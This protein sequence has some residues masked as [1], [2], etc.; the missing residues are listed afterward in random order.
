[1]KEYYSNITRLTLIGHS[2]RVCHHHALA[3]VTTQI[4]RMFLFS[5]SFWRWA[6]RCVLHMTQSYEL[7]GTRI[8]ELSYELSGTRDAQLWKQLMRASLTGGRE[9]EESG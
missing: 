9:P 7:C 3:H 1:M 2:Q 6:M 8:L 4:G 5:I